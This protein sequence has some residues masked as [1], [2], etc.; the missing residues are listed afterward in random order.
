M[1]KKGVI[2]GAVCGV[3]GAGI[4]IAVAVAFAKERKRVW[5]RLGELDRDGD[6][7]WIDITESLASLRRQVDEYVGGGDKNNDTDNS[8]A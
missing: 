8:N 3:L 1:K 2:I 6:C 4:S 5:G 7:D